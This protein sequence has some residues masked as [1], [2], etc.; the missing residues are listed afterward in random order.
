MLVMRR[1]VQGALAHSNMQAAYAGAHQQRMTGW[2]S[3]W[4]RGEVGGKGKSA[5]M[6]QMM[7]LVPA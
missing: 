4:G 1:A 7:R 2:K 3:D 6:L 5:P